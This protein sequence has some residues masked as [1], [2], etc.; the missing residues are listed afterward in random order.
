MAG[1]DA[2]LVAPRHAQVAEGVGGVAGEV[3]A[4]RI[5]EGLRL[6]VVLGAVLAQELEPAAQRPR[7][8][9]QRGKVARAAW[10]PSM[11]LWAGTSSGFRP[12][13]D[14][15]LDARAPGAE[16][17]HP[18]VV[19]HVVVAARPGLAAHHPGIMV[20]AHAVGL[21]VIDDADL[22]ARHLPPP[23]RRGIADAEVPGGV[24]GELRSRLDGG[25]ASVLLGA[26][27]LPR[28]VGAEHRRRP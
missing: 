2:A 23:D 24:D 28:P 22:R 20:E 27:Q 12:S 15:G 13:A 8:N 19:G 26:L 14:H 25:D 17:A 10:M 9:Q 1:T 11:S 16:L 3:V 6:V 18:G 21:V 5:P 7:S 4:R